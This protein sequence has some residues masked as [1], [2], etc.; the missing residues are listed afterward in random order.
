MKKYFAPWAILLLLMQFISCQDDAG[1]DPRCADTV[2]EAPGAA[3]TGFGDTDHAVDG[4]H[5]AGC[6]S[7]NAVDLYSLSNDPA[8]ENTFIIL[9]WSGRRLENGPGTDFVVFENP[10]D[11]DTCGN[12]R[13]FMDQLVVSV[14]IDGTE[15][16]DFPHDY[17]APDESV[18]SEYHSYWHGFAGV[19]PVLFN[20]KSNPVDPFD[21]AAAGGD[22]FDLDDLVD[23]G[24]PETV[25]KIKTEGCRFIKL[26]AAGAVKN[27]DTDNYFPQDTGANG[28][29][30]DG[31]YGRYLA[32]E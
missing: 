11:Y 8:D 30:I 7:Q 23:T 20:E 29:D 32:E 22:H 15:W 18:Y 26:T 5:G 25:E 12:D 19:T 4:V 9:R 16:I 24:A 31:V 13:R 28:P 6:T 27:N 14:S 3:G 21:P 2:I 1:L 10:F 17:T